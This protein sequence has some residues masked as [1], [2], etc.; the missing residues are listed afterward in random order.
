MIKYWKFDT[1]SN[2]RRSTF[3][4]KWNLFTE[5][6]IEGDKLANVSW[7]RIISVTL[8]SL[9]FFFTAAGENKRKQDEKFKEIN[10]SKKW[11]LRKQKHYETKNKLSINEIERRRNKNRKHRKISRIQKFTNFIPFFIFYRIQEFLLVE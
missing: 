11:S 4:W 9:Q 8:N 3:C 10:C 5:F 6:H 2:I 1:L 7:R